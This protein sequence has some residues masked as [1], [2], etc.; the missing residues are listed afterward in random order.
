MRYCTAILFV[1]CFYSGRSQTVFPTDSIGTQTLSENIYNKQL[2]GDSLS[3]SFCIVIKKEVKAHKHQY[4][5]EH[6]VVLEGE[7]IMKLDGESLPIKKGD[8]I[9]IP[10]NSIHSVKR[11]SKVPLKVLSIQSPAFNGNDRIFVEEEE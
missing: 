10:K 6:V 11:V 1:I 7:G 3:T 9:F 2:F 5:S 8:L 4:H